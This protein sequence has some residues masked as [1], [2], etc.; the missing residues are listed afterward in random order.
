MN[1]AEVGERAQ[2]VDAVD[3]DRVAVRLREGEARQRLQVAR[4]QQRVE[5]ARQL[6]R[7][8]QRALQILIVINRC[9]SL[10]LRHLHLGGGHDEARAALLD[11]S[12]QVEAYSRQHHF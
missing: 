11:I 5:H 4:R 10:T 12:V 6:V 9:I 3:D 1:G 8:V 7:Q 2:V